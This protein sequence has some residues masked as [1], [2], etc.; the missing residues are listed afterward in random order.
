VQPTLVLLAD[1]RLADV[2]ALYRKAFDRALSGDPSGALTVATSA[3]E[4]MLRI[5]LEETG[6]TLGPLADK[7][8][9]TGWIS[10][11]T[12]ELVKKAHV[13]RQESDAHQAGTSELDVAML[14]LHVTGS[15][16]LYLGKT[17]PFA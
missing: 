6:S 8:R 17:G 12:A 2:D 9:A 10:S 13:L 4:E 11:G 14:G 1:E 7:A 15:L 3:L 5:G 16:L